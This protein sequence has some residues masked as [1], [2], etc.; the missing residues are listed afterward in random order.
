MTKWKTTFSVGMR[1]LLVGGALAMTAVGCRRGAPSED[2]PIHIVP[3]MDHQEKFRSQAQN[4]FFEDGAAMRT[5]VPGT[6]ARGW[7]REDGTT[8]VVLSITP[9][10]MLVENEEGP[11]TATPESVGYVTTIP[12]AELTTYYTGRVNGEPEAP[13]VGRSP[14]PATRQMLERGRERYDIYCLPCHGTVGDGGGMVGVRAPAFMAPSYHT[15]IMI[16]KPDGEIF[17]TI[18]HGKNRMQ[19][20]AQQIPVADRWA[21]VAY[22]R[23]LQRS[24]TA[25]LD[26]V[27]QNERGALSNP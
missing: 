13:F 26:D 17:N 23:A 12:A 14:V 24:Q 22:V 3:N 10:G 25:T 15:Q 7:L 27:P 20:Y 6:V 11:T 8:P 1:A 9:R 4:D 19:G 21:I 2:P 16:D 18:T 5:P